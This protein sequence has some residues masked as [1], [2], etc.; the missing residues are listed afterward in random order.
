MFLLPGTQSF[1]RIIFFLPLIALNFAKQISDYTG[2]PF[3]L[4]L[5]VYSDDLGTKAT[6]RKKRSTGLL[7]QQERDH[8]TI[9]T[10]PVNKVVR[11]T[12]KKKENKEVYIAVL[13]SDR[14]LPSYFSIPQLLP[15]SLSIW[16]LSLFSR[17]SDFCYQLGSLGYPA[18][19]CQCPIKLVV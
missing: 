13:S 1:I 15:G 3:K 9:G 6:V 2:Q 7:K 5:L 10:Q 17:E 8:S 18:R 11:R 14:A 16:F 12:E 19:L 4:G